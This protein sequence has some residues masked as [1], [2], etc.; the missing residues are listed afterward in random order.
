VRQA[1]LRDLL[2]AGAAA[3]VFSGIPST[4][5]ALARGDDATEATRA[6][7]AMLVPADSSFVALLAAAAIVHTVISFF[8]AAI[9]MRVLPRRHVMPGAIGAALMIGVLDLKLI[10]PLFFPEVAALAFL[11]Q[12]ADHAMW[13]AMLGAVLAYRW[14]GK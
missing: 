6:A 7:G 14:R 4:L 13:G 11:P 2:W 5:W 12:M 9:L 8:W 3:T 10:A 1:Y